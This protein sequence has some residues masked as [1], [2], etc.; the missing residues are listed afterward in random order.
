MLAFLRKRKM[1]RTGHCKVHLF[2]FTQLLL[3]S[4]F[5]VYSCDEYKVLFRFIH[6]FFLLYIV[7]SVIYVLIPCFLFSIKPRLADPSFKPQSGHILAAVENF[8]NLL[9]IRYSSPLFRLRTANAIQV[10]SLNIYVVTCHFNKK[11]I[12]DNRR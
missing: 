3:V 6:I 4:S 12:D 11:N 10:L 9:Q 1:R 2:K 5:K 7:I 8:L